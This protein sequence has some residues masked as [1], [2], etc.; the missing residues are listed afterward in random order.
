[1]RKAFGIW[2]VPAL[3]LAVLTGCTAHHTT[4]RARE[5][6]RPPSAKYV[7]CRATELT[8]RLGRIGLGAGQ[9][10]RY[11]VLIN[12]G[13]RACRLVGGPTVIIGVR[14]D[15]DRVTL[16]TGASSKNLNFGLAQPTSGLDKARR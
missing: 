5:A 1:M 9:Y 10:I 7:A 3:A 8:G 11:L 12:S 4:P 16:A 14:A 6:T 2:A 13:D 15:G